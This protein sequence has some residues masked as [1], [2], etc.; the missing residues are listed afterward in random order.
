MMRTSITHPLQI[1]S[2]HV[3]SRAGLIGLT[4]CPG[5][6]QDNALTGSWDRDLL[7]DLREIQNW[8]ADVLVTLME[9]HELESLGVSQLGNQAERFD[10]RWLHL[11][12]VDVS[13]PDT[14]FETQWHTAGPSLHRLLQSGGRC[15]L[16]CKGGLGRTGTIAARL[17]VEFGMEPQAAI[18][19][20][21]QSRPGAIET[22]GQ[23]RYILSLARQV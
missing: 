11:P 14:G 13:I 10:L 3:P 1:D 5:K 23:E 8:G 12:I 2:L 4:F 15:V 22:V 6:K 16:H 19:A 7:A 18:E 9:Q 21:R 17:L 20:V